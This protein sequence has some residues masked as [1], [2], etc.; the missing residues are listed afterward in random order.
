MPQAVGPCTGVICPPG[1]ICAA[2]GSCA[3][4][5]CTGVICP[6][7][8]H[9]EGGVC[10]GSGVVALPPVTPEV[11]VATAISAQAEAERAKDIADTTTAVALQSKDERALAEA[12]RRLYEA[13]IAAVNA[14]KA[15]AEAAASATI[16]ATAQAAEQAE[17]QAATAAAAAQPVADTLVSHSQPTDMTAPVAGGFPWGKLAAGFLVLKFFL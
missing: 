11:A 8:Q 15:A 3:D 9:C 14:S 5:R 17:A 7:G 1:W 6:N 2:D 10:V 12:K 4:T 13:E 16:A